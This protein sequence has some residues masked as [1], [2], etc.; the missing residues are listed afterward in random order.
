MSENAATEHPTA[1]DFPIGVRVHR[2]VG[3]MVTGVIVEP[4]RADIQRAMHIHGAANLPH[5][6]LVQWGY[7]RSWEYYI[8]LRHPGISGIPG[9]L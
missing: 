3:Q 9:D 7:W 6:A 5:L 8:D 4:T 1:E 2:V